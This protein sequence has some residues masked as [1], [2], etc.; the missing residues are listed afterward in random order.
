MKNMPIQG[1]SADMTK[2]A[3]VRIHEHLCQQV[4]R[5][6]LNDAGLVNTVH[7]ELVVECATEDAERVAALVR[8]EME[9]AHMTLC[10]RVPPLVEVQVAPHWQH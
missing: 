7:D 1:T 5:Q 6:Q 8:V 2:L 9:Q 10:K 4:H 3:M